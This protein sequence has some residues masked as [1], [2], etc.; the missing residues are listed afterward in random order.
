V[1]EHATET[2][3]VAGPNDSTSPNEI[4][5]LDLQI[6]AELRRD[7]RTSNRD[8]ARL[9]GYSEA[10]IRRRVKALIDQ[11]RIKIV[12]I[13]DPYLLGYAIDVIIDIEVQPGKVKEVA[14][15]F[16]ELDNVRAVTITT[17]A[18]DLVVAALFRSNDDLLEFFASSVGEIPGVVR[19]STSHTLRVVKRSF[20]LFPEQLL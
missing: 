20:D 17:G 2:T 19:T 16:A 6:I 8:L 15:R 4:D 5:D 11:G 12:A 14:R 18:A 9:L 13:A 3:P 10:T 7:G 1:L